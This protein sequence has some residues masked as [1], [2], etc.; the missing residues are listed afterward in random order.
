MTEAQ[1]LASNDPEAMLDFLSGKAS[2][3][4]LRLFLCACARRLWRFIRL[5]PCRQAV[6]VAEKYADGQAGEQER[7]AAYLAA[8]EL[9]WRIPD[10]SNA[11][12]AEV[13]SDWSTAV[14]VWAAG[15]S[16]SFVVSH[17]SAREKAAIFFDVF[18]ITTAKVVWEPAA[19]VTENNTQASLL[20]D[21]FDPFHPVPLDPHWLTPSV[22][23]LAQGIYD[24]RA[25]DQL[26]QLAQ[27]LEE[28]GCANH[29]IHAHCRGPGP[30]VRGCWVIDLILGK[31]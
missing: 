25:F 27:A 28:A 5:E 3:R 1:W 29:A 13:R 6:R 17:P 4:K 31:R 30:H 22:V 2:D 24:Q 23:S 18:F 19:R 21:L 20:R 15:P 11:P 16:D 10:D 9:A 7:E 26:P 14:A 12:L 8:R